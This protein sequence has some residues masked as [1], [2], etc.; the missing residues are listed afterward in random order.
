MRLEAKGLIN[1]EKS[2]SDRRALILTLTDIG[3]MLVSYLAAMADKTDAR[4]F[5][6]AGDASLEIIEKVMKWIVYLGR[7]RFV[8]PGRCRIVRDHRYMNLDWDGDE[9]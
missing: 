7:F 5:G 1:R 4:N 9:T 3:R 2:V 6:G 8:P